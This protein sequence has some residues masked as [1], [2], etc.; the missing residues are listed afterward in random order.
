MAGKTEII[1]WIIGCEGH[2]DAWV[3]APDWPLAT[4]RA[5]EFWGVPWREVAARCVCKRREKALKGIC[6]RCG[7]FF[8][9]GAKMCDVCLKALEDDEH[10][11]QQYLKH[12][13]GKKRA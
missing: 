4:V 11:L 6:P 3:T 10:N 13:Y 8:Y 2:T 9:G 7:H 1:T 5:A 12:R